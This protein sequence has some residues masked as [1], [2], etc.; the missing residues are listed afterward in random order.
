MYFKV[1]SPAEE[2]Q[3][4]NYK[5]FQ[6]ACN[7]VITFIYV[8]SI[9]RAVILDLTELLTRVAYDYYCNDDRSLYRYLPKS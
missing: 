8:H 2:L 6:S 1:W 7:R 9:D 5:R 4:R 3:T